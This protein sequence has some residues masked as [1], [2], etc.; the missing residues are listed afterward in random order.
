MHMK[1]LFVLFMSLLCML[2]D[3]AWAQKKARE[4]QVHG[5]AIY[6]MGENDDIT[7]A[8]A[9]KRCIELAKANAIKAEFSELV[10][11]DVISTYSDNDS[12]FWENTI[13]KAKGI[14]LSDDREP[15]VTRSI[16]DDKVRFEA[17]VWGIAREIIQSQTQLKWR[18]FKK[19]ENETEDF[20]QGERVFVS[21]TAPAKGYVA[22]YL[23]TGVEGDDKTYCLLPYPKD[24]DGRHEIMANR[25]YFFFDKEKDN[26]PNVLYYKLETEHE[27][28]NNQLV[29]IYS[30]TPFTKCIDNPGDKKTPRWLSTKDFQKWLLGL[31][32]DDKDMVVNKKWVTI[33]KPE[34]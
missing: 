6:D 8:E 31:Q 26:D 33:R 30:P 18:V 19:G 21:F 5:T 15:V 10:T 29:I 4:A 24:Q 7:P 32:R 23:S 12:H 14:W 22:I 16:I 17:E 27:M 28:E 3:T 20:L 2:P 9:R 11:S 25:N 13:A 1:K 34:N